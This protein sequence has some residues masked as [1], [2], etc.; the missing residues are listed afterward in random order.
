MTWRECSF[1]RVV[2]WRKE[3]VASGEVE[4]GKQGEVVGIITTYE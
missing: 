2:A 1:D 4:I 3:N